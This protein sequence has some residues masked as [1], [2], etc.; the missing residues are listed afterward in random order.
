MDRTKRTI[1]AAIFLSQEPVALEKLSEKL[2][3]EIKEVERVIEELLEE[4]KSRGIILRKVA[5]GYKFFTA[6]DLSDFLKP[7]I[8]DKPVKLSRHLLEV[9][10]II[11]YKQPITKK[12]I[13]Q[14]RGQNPDGAIKSLLEKGLIEVAGRSDSPGRPKL[15][16]TTKEFL[17]HFGLESIDDLPEISLEEVL[18]EQSY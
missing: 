17:Y 5:G 6:P 14:I 13:A 7:F 9:L 1:E 11:A 12:E 8:E 4:Y 10:A 3:L 2:G 16:R 15:Y 18:D